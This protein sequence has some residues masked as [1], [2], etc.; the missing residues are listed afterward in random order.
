MSPRQAAYFLACQKVSTE[1]GTDC[2]RPCASLRVN[3]RHAIR[4]AVRQNSLRSKLL[5]SNRL[6]KFD[7]DALALC[8]ANARSP[9]GVPQARTHGW[10]RE[11]TACES[12]DEICL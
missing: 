1:Y 10:K 11:R 6:R 2:P 8:G 4:S 5:R 9:N 12:C 3:L 7:D